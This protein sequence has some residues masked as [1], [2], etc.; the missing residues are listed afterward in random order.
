M[1]KR[2]LPLYLSELIG[3][4]FLVFFGCGAMILAE[5][6]P[7]Y[8]G[9]FIPVIF[10]AI[11]GVMIYGVG[12]IS[13]AHFNPAVTISFWAIKRFPT[14]KI[15]GYIT[16]QTV[17]AGL[18]SL[19]HLVIF[20]GDH[21]FG[22]THFEDT[23]IVAALVE[24]IL[25]F[26]LMFI[27]TSVATDSRAI[28]E[29]AGLAIGSSVALCAFVGGPITGASMNPARSLAPAIFEG[30]HFQLVLY[31]F[32]PVIGCVCGAKV[33]ETIRCEK[34]SMDSNDHGCC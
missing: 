27:I 32:I 3:T 26:L 15:L 19:S 6:N 2:Y 28:G 14:E 31:L 34:E 13:G 18:A 4:F 9:G 11:V 5:M 23:F 8:N 30:A 12:H 33:Y 10:G 7:T 17:G 29:L 22:S 25:S 16:A 24:F 1:S 21:S 20:G